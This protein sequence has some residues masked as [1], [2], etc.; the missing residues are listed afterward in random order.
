MSM[1]RNNLSTSA[2]ND[3][4]ILTKNLSADLNEKHAEKMMGKKL[5]DV[6]NFKNILI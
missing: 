5:K 4:Y 2:N 6:P 3:S 1:L